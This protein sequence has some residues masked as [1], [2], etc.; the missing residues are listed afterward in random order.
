MPNLTESQCAENLHETNWRLRRYLQTLSPDEAQVAPPSPQLIS[1][2]LSEL[3]RSGEWLRRGL[4]E[5]QGPQL[6]AELDEYRQNLQCLRDR[7]PSI[8]SHL[9]AEKARLESERARIDSAAE[10]AQSS[11]QTL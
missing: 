10:W 7:M 3:L 1:E 8:H 6:R 2:L 5:S 11:R 9:L 4:P